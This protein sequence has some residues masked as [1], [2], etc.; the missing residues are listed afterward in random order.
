MQRE[1]QQHYAV[2]WSQTQQCAH[3]DTLART[4]EG[5][6]RAWATLRTH[7]FLIVAICTTRG[8]ADAVCQALQET[9]EM[10]RA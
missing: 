3:V 2:S 7:D 8:E 1:A 4:V 10:R 5:N 9:R 6:R